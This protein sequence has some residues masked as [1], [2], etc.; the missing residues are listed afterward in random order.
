[1]TSIWR[2]A[3]RRKAERFPWPKRWVSRSRRA[4]S[5]SATAKP[6][7]LVVMPVIVLRLHLAGNEETWRVAGGTAPRAEG[8]DRSCPQLARACRTTDP[9]GQFVKHVAERRER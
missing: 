7:V 3:S 5:S 6:M 2:I 4:S 1:M 9:E 8:A